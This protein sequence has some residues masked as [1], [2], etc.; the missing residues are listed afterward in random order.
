[1]SYPLYSFDSVAEF[2]RVH[3]LGTEAEFLKDARLIDC[4]N[5][6][7]LL[8]NAWLV[9]RIRQTTKRS[10][11]ILLVQP[12]PHGESK[13]PAQGAGGKVRVA[14]AD[15]T[16]TTYWDVNRIEN[17]IALLGL[18]ASSM[19]KL[20][21]FHV[22][23]ANAQHHDVLETPI[24]DV[25]SSSSQDSLSPS[26]IN[27]SP[28]GGIL[29]SSSSSRQQSPNTSS[30]R[31]SK[32]CHDSV[33][34]Q[35]TVGLVPNLAAH[36]TP[37]NV[38][39]VNF[40]LHA[41]ESTKDSEIGALEVLH[42]RHQNATDRQLDAFSYFVTLKNPA[43]HVTIYDKLPH[44]RKT[45]GEPRWL[46][47]P[48]GKKFQ[49]LNPQQKEAYIHGFEN[50]PCGICILPGG[51]GAGK[52]HFNLFTIA[53][54]Q[55]KPIMRFG[56][57]QNEYCKVLFIVDMNSPVD[58]VAN[59]MVR[60][61]QELGMKKKII[62]MKGWGFEVK[63]S[64]KLNQAEDA[65]AKDMPDV[66]FTNQFLDTAKT[67]AVEQGT[68]VRC[69]APSLDEAAWERYEAYKNAKYESITEYMKKD[70]FGQDEALVVPLRFRNL[71]YDL[72]R[73]TLADA[74]FIA[75]TPVAASNHFKGMFRPDLVFFDESPHARELCNLIAIANFNPL[76][77][78]FCGDY[79]QTV[80]YV[81]SAG[82]ESQ[83]PYAK[84]MQVSMMERAA[85]AGVIRHELLM[86]HRA[87]GGLHRLA[88]DLWYDGKMVSG[89]DNA[90]CQPLI[91]IRNYIS[92]LNGSKACVV[93]RLIVH[94]R[95][96]PGEKAEGTSCW[97]PAH[98]NWVMARV[99]ELLTDPHFRKPEK[100]EPGTVLI[101]SPYNAAFNHYKKELKKLPQWAQKRVEARTVDVSQGHEAEF[102]FLDLSR[103]RST[104]FLD[105]PNRLCVA[106]TRARLG[107]IVMIDPI[108]PKC[109]HLQQKSQHLRRIYVACESGDKLP[110]NTNN[111]VTSYGH[112]TWAD[113][114]GLEN[115]DWAPTLSEDNPTEVYD[116]MQEVDLS[117]FQPATSSGRKSVRTEMLE[118]QKNRMQAMRCAPRVL[119]FD[120]EACLDFL[121]MGSSE[122]KESAKE[123]AKEKGS[124]KEKESVVQEEEVRP[125][126]E[127]SVL[128]L[129][130]GWLSAKTDY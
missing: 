44:M 73:D 18:S 3:K 110:H 109:D 121:G 63:R 95:R 75:T 128:T 48:L 36:L 30:K 82:Q 35:P 23:V 12:G 127:V 83:N 40:Y 58:D 2:S 24:I 50:I 28:A 67:M 106:L 47:T 99:K 16:F 38:L 79:R 119:K 91:H 9:S 57:S 4:I 64:N 21:A 107:E 116:D 33:E 123:S 124:V 125:S 17:P 52:T 96:S 129:L 56:K 32:P 11:Y 97:N 112:I 54:A 111:Q 46:S 74:D 59:R 120:R 108:M 92:H 88:S 126:E 15:G 86:N 115:N 42:G 100:M 71:V 87:Y 77:W 90:V 19:A 49:M 7:G 68:T 25:E 105:D 118:D 98:T 78:I 22:T 27:R 89:S 72:Y 70:L 6:E 5:S 85:R 37:S 80:P 45:I 94:L 65:V 69:E 55:S 101:I 61:Y 122:E 41:S 10:E 29:P 62:R 53:M 102:V 103:E 113:M 14:F 43:F 34:Y 60:L 84:Q 93:P 26:G 117:A 66:D 31:S 39:T 8:F 114:E 104:D 13:I 81:G 20:A 130:G 1:M 51:P 76:A